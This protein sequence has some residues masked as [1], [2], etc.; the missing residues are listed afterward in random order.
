[1]ESNNELKD[2]DNKSCNCFYFDDIMKVG[3]FDSGNILL[4]EKSC[5]NSNENIL[6]YD[7]SY[8]F[9]MG[10]KPLRITFDKTDGS[11]KIMIELDIQYHLVQKDMICVTTGIS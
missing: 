7:I 8:K 10:A 9:F 6:I 3:D 11:I 5:K 4:D 2:I 1:M